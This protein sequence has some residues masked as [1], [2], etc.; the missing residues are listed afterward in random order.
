MLIFTLLALNSKPNSPPLTATTVETW[1]VAMEASVVWAMAMAVDVAASAGWAMVVA[2][3]ATDMALFMEASDLA[4]IVVH[5]A[6]EVM[7]SLTST[8]L[9][10]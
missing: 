9:W 4:A 6:M 10:P 8:E 2:S 3:E 5:C 7:D 1:A